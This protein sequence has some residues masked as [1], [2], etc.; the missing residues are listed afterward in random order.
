MIIYGV[1]YLGSHG[2]LRFQ[3][4]NQVWAERIQTLDAYAGYGILLIVTIQLVLEFLRDFKPKNGPN[5]SLF[6]AV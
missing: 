1:F 2:L 5:A 3:H 6:F 4:G